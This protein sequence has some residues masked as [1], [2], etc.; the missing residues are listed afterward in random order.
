MEKFSEWT[1]T[2]FPP[3]SVL[4][5]EVRVVLTVRFK[6]EELVGNQRCK[7]GKASGSPLNGY[8]YEGP[9][10]FRKG[11]ISGGPTHVS[12]R[13]RLETGKHKHKF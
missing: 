8:D 11:L 9:E 1:P 5:Y 13:R 2:T 7:K 3:F 4:T 6:L 10:T 12:R